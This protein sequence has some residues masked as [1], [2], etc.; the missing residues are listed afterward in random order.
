MVVASLIT[1]MAREEDWHLEI[2]KEDEA[3]KK[4]R[5]AKSKHGK[6]L[7][8]EIA[9]AESCCNEGHLEIA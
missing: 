8:E 9:K 1:V 2:I 5:R 7:D 4:I 6:N 3:R